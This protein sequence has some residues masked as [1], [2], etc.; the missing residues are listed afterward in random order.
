MQVRAIW[1]MESRLFRRTIGTLSSTA[2]LPEGLPVLRNTAR[3]LLQA[4]HHL[5]S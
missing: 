1:T 3:Q 2:M 4:L 5:H